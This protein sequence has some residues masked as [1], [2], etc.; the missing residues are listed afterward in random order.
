MEVAMASKP[1]SLITSVVTAGLFFSSSYCLT[2]VPDSGSQN[3][4]KLLIKER[5]GK[6]RKG[7]E[8]KRGRRGYGHH[9]RKPWI[10]IAQV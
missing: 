3:Y 6:E 10:D 8:G 1:R 5:K 2:Q 4:V 7:K 9:M